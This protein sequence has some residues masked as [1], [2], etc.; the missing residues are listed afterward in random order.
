MIITSDYKDYY[1]YVQ[2]IH[3][4]NKSGK[5]YVRK[6]FVENAEYHIPYYFVLPYWEYSYKTGMFL[7]PINGNKCYTSVLLI[8][9]KSHVIV[10]EHFQ[11]DGNICDSKTIHVVNYNH[12]FCKIN[13]VNKLMYQISKNSIKNIE[14]CR[15]LKSPVVKF[16]VHQEYL[17]VENK[18]PRLGEIGFGKIYPAEE[19]YQD[20]SYFI[21]NVMYIEEKNIIMSDKEKVVSHGFDLKSSFRK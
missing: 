1:D 19:I 4:Y 7:N 13:C 2:Y 12:K 18:I 5:E 15:K 20:L 9:E 8:G 3:G 6:D 11:V 21:D 10:E 16:I 14:I 17:L